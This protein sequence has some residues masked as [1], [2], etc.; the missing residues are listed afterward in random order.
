MP[1]IFFKEPFEI[2][3]GNDCLA[4]AGRG[5]NEIAPMAMHQPLGF[6]GIKNAFLERVRANIKKDRPLARPTPRVTDGIP[7]DLR[8]VRI[9]RHELPAVPIRF[10][11]RDELGNDVRLIL[12]SH[13]EVP[14]QSAGHRC[15]GHVGRANIRR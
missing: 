1:L 10:K 8:F 9:E 4:R 11:L 15:L 7:E 14:L 5:D 2:K 6:K 13:L 3:R 12:R